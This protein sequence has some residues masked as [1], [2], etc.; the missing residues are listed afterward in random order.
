MSA[1]FEKVRRTIGLG[2]DS[3]GDLA[4]LDSILL[5]ADSY[6]DDQESDTFSNPVDEVLRRLGALN[7][8]TLAKIS[9]M[10]NSTKVA[11]DA[12]NVH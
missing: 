4:W 2:P 3:Q 10:L 9:T 6:H 5:Y 12:G 11:F 8:H 1:A 7:P